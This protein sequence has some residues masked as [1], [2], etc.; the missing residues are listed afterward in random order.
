M[1]RAFLATGGCAL[2]VGLACA[3]WPGLPPRLAPCPGPVPAVASLPAGDFGWRERVRYRGGDVDAGFL[4]VA[5]KRGDRLVLVGLNP[6]G[7]KAFSVTQQQGALTAESHL[8]RALAVP[9]ENVLRDWYALRAR[10][11]GAAGDPV[12][13]ARPAC[14]YEATFVPGERHPL[15]P[16]DP[17]PGASPSP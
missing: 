9:P 8:G 6:F 14:G 16:V 3:A 1:S 2:L 15:D 13:I 10:G 5:E 11:G 4:V 17:G 12:R 7:A